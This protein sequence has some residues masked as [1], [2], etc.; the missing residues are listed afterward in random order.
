MTLFLVLIAAIILICVWLNNLS[1]RIGI[2]TLLA[3][4][5]LGVIFGNNGLIPIHLEDQ[6][7]AKDVCTAALIFIMFYG[8]FGTK[9]D[10]AK[11]IA[12][13]AG[14]LASV[15]VFLTALLTGVFCHFVLRWGWVESLLLGSVISSTDAASVFSILR[16]RKLGMKN[17]ISP[18]LEMESGSNDPCSYMLTV[19]MLSIMN[20]SASGGHIVWMIFAQLFF[21]AVCGLGIA[22]ISTILL[23][24][25]KFQTDG[26]DSLFILA[27]AIASYAIP[28]LI[29]GNGYLS[30]YI[31]GIILGN[32]DF[33]NK[34]SLVSFFDGLTGLMQVLIFFILGL[35]AHPATMHKA[36][37]PAIAVFFALL[38]F[39]RPITVVAV[40]AP[41]KKY[42]L[43]QMKVISFAGL[44]GA[45]SI[46][47]AI[48]ATTG[49][50]FLTQDIF[51]IVFII[52]LISI[53][54]QGSLIPVIA[55][56]A[57]VIDEDANVLKTFNDY[58]EN[59]EMQF[60]RLDL[61]KNGPWNGRPIKDLHLPVSV[62]IVLVIRNGE[63]IVPNGDTV[64]QEGDCVIMLSRTYEDKDTSIEEV[65]VKSNSKWLGKTLSEY[66]K[67][68]DYIVLM[69]QRGEKNIVPHGNSVL[70][71][72]DVLTICRV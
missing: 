46:V 65:T 12:V 20:G 67:S 48:M 21:A 8:G 39:A 35:L 1:F 54:L 15:G 69:I 71:E 72:G 41:F 10:S 31:V 63:K 56:A 4:I 11:P 29:G 34:K 14:L 2:P 66:R 55:K 16:S 24:R 51:N 22:K 45:A 28:D 43:R 27:I 64:L 6:E 17:N 53:S 37:L 32:T 7:F 23:R 57:D 18:L 59:T 70:H 30:T 44:R 52:V 42:G 25:I 40:L 38:L 47:F 62:L 49:N 60:S 5:L 13:E 19:V 50:Q 36:I 58:A 3:F 9:W 26:F 68:N 33:K 61:A